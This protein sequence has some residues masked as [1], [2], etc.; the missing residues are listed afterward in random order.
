M[1]YNI[2]HVAYAFIAHHLRAL[3]PKGSYSTFRQ[4]K[5][6]K[7]VSRPYSCAY[8]GNVLNS[9]STTLYDILRHLRS[10]QR[11][12]VISYHPYL[13]VPYS[14]ASLDPNA[15]LYLF[16]SMKVS[17]TRLTRG[18]TAV[19]EN[20]KLGHLQQPLHSCSDVENFLYGLLALFH[21]ILE[22]KDQQYL[23]NN[24]VND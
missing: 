8:N 4:I 14:I 18:A 23:L 20:A 22:N 7:F 9:I 1:L 24:G 12:I 13:F 3:F 16:T 2:E 17:F 11:V 10:L 19:I 15:V 5:H 21:N 6:G